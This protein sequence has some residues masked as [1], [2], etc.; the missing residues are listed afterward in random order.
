MSIH[1]NSNRLARVATVIAVV[2]LTYS[3]LHQLSNSIDKPTAKSVDKVLPSVNPIKQMLEV[4]PGSPKQD[5]TAAAI[6]IDVSGS[7]AEKVSD[8]KGQL[9]PK[10]ELAR[11]SAM[12]IFNLAKQFTSQNPDKLLKI[13]IYEFSSR[14]RQPSCRRIVPLGPV[15]VESSRPR[16]ASM[17]PDGGTPIGDA[18]ITA[19]LDLDAI[20]LTRLHIMV[21]TDGENN[22]GYSP[23]D[24][25]DVISRMPQQNRA[26][27]YFI[28]FDISA[29]KFEAVRSAGGLVLSAANEQE[30]RQTMEYVF[31]GRILAEQPETP[32]TK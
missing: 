32:Q 20:S 28:A 6:V 23:G 5:G 7:M 14:E 10:I 11:N 16:I 17:Y 25:V 30:L 9:K 31:T 26:S 21:I 22:Q 15:D 13:G 2:V 24:V 3:V 4:G 27:I 12:N 18:I 8:T 19:K 1:P 29:E